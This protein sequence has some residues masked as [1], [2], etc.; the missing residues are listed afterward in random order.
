MPHFTVDWFSHNI[1]TWE[2]VFNSLGW[3]NSE[4]HFKALEVR[5]CPW[6]GSIVLMNWAEAGVLVCHRLALGKASLRAG[7]SNMCAGLVPLL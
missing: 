4:K 7:F 6:N 3:L 2:R 1:P 5:L